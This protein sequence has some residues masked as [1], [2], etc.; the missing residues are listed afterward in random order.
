MCP[1][2]AF[3]QETLHRTSR[4]GTKH[5]LYG[6]SDSRPKLPAAATSTKTAKKRKHACVRVP[7][8][9]HAPCYPQGSHFHNVIIRYNVVL[10]EKAD[11]PHDDFVKTEGNRPLCEMLTLERLAFE[12]KRDRLVSYIPKALADLNADWEENE[13]MFKAIESDIPNGAGALHDLIARSS[14]QRI[15]LFYV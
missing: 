7:T 2:K 10:S 4:V 6:K 11:P 5:P 15:N 9:R 1:T 13:V 8:K 14:S 12:C 3:G